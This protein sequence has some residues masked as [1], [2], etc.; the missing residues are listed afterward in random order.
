MTKKFLAMLV[1]LLM[2][3]TLCACDA[4]SNRVEDKEKICTALTD[5]QDWDMAHQVMNEVVSYRESGALEYMPH[6]VY[7]LNA[8]YK[9]YTF[10]GPNTFYEVV[11]L[12]AEE[13]FV[14]IIH[15]TGAHGVSFWSGVRKGAQFYGLTENY[16]LL[17][18]QFLSLRK[19]TVRLANIYTP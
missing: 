9:T 4:S 16:I 15:N 17:S 8:P 3:G 7:N 14:M 2:L 10:D 19:K 6:G 18:L 13:D 1:A 5:I 11:C 12:N